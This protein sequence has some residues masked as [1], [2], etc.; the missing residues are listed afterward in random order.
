MTA[1]PEHDERVMA[2]VTAALDKPAAERDAYL[3]IACAGNDE[4]YREAAEVVTCEKLMGNFM[5]HPMV[6]LADP[7]RSFRP[8]QIVSDR[9]EIVRTIGEGGMGIVYEA[10]DRKRDHRIALKFAKAGFQRL[11]SPEL[12]GALSV[13]HPNI[14]LVN[15][16]HDTEIDGAVVDFTAM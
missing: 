13:R 9:F 11:L 6:V 4:L 3:R 10:H 2:I 1:S 14:C 5:L 16:I 7:A 8:G 15:Q 12:E